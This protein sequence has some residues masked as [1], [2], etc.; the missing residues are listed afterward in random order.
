MGGKLYN[1]DLY[2]AGDITFEATAA[3]RYKG[4]MVGEGAGSAIVNAASPNI[5]LNRLLVRMDS[6]SGSFNPVLA[7][8]VD[9]QILLIMLETAG[10]NSATIIAN[11]TTYSSIQFTADGQGVL[12]V[13]D[14]TNGTWSIIASYATTIV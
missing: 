9:D 4:A 10:G 8:G 2:T 5:P 14:A 7:D 12:L 3:I 11:L 6:T 13:F 1:T